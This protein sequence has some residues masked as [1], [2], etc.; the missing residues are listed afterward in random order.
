[1][2]N[3]YEPPVVEVINFPKQDVLAAS[4][5]VVEYDINNAYVKLSSFWYK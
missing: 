4:T 5:D 3:I 1:M 2:K